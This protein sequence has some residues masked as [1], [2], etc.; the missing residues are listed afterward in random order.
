[1]AVFITHGLDAEVQERI[2][3]VINMVFISRFTSKINGDLYVIKDL[4]DGSF[5]CVV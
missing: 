5:G 4:L 2:S 1:M 3:L